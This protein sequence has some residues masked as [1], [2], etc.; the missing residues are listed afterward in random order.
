MNKKSEIK[1]DIPN[2]MASY[3]WNNS[4]FSNPQ[5]ERSV[6]DFIFNP[7]NKTNHVAS[8]QKYPFKAGVIKCRVLEVPKYRPSP[9]GLC[10]SI[11][12]PN[13][14]SGFKFDGVIHSMPNVHDERLKMDREY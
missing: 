12:R 4:K 2:T 14:G 11:H 7:D 9:F 6:Y 10:P 8:Q 1:S 5:H 3:N 13:T